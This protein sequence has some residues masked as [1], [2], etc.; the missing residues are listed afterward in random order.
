MWELIHSKTYDH[1][2]SLCW[3]NNVF[4]NYNYRQRIHLYQLIEK[5]VCN[6][7]IKDYVL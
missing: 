2:L 1:S 3:P 7:F 5:V 6:D 4:I